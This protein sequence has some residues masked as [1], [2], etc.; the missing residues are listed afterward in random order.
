MGITAIAIIGWLV[1]DHWRRYGLLLLGLLFVLRFFV[2]R[3]GTFY[4]ITLPEISRYTGGVCINWLLELAGIIVIALSALNNL[5]HRIR[6][7]TTI[8]HP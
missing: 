8:S 2:V 3:I 5:R 4:G 6:P 7:T 1:R